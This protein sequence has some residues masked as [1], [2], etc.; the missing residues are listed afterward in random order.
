MGEEEGQE[1]PH[2]LL[3][4]GQGLTPLEGQRQEVETPG[5]GFFNWLPRLP[6]LPSVSGRSLPASGRREPRPGVRGAMEGGRQGDAAGA[7]TLAG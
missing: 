3:P 2:P 6:L 7:E 4:W 1:S 5:A